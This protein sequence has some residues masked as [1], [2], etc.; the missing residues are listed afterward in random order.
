M[1][2]QAERRRRKRTAR[3]REPVAAPPR[4]AVIASDRRAYVPREDGLSMLRSKERLT[5]VQAQ[6]GRT[7]G[8]LYRAAA[9]PDGAAIRSFLD[10]RPRGCGSAAPAPLVGSEWVSE[11]RWRLAKAQAV[12]CW[13]SGMI[14]ALGLICGQGLHPR[15]I[16]TVQREAEQIETALR[17]ALDMLVAHW[18]DERFGGVGDWV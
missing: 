11:C 16:S 13:H 2:S 14:A 18:R 9:L 10:L 8:A 12:L 15:E 1:A 3:A 17:L 6:A 4:P 5:A 7:Y